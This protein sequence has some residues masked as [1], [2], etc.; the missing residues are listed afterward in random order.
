MDVGEGV[1]LLCVCIYI[2]QNE[3]MLMEHAFTNV[4]GMNHN[5]I[6]FSH[7]KL[8]LIIHPTSGGLYVKGLRL[9]D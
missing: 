3:L 2:T 5:P 6:F 9:K 8:L 4:V 7:K 1:Q